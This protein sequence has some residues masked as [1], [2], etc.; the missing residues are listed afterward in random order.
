VEPL[1]LTAADVADSAQGRVV[2]GDPGTAIGRIVIDSRTLTAGDCFVAIQGER[3]D[4]HDFIAEAVAR[5][6]GAVVLSR[7]QPEPLQR[8]AGVVIRVDDTT[9]GLQA[10]AREVPRPRKSPRSF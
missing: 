7:D 10:V 4:G 5:G 8:P 6:A 9:R 1:S 2:H 3:F